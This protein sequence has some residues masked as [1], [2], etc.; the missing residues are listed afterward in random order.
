MR[1]LAPFYTTLDM[2]PSLT[3]F[4]AQFQHLVLGFLWRQWSA[5]GVAGQSRTGDPWVVDPE[6][7]LLFSTVLARHEP[8]LFDEILD[9]LHLNGS[10]INLQRLSH[11]QKHYEPGD[12]AVLAAIATHLAH[13]TA[14]SKWKVL[15]QVETTTNRPPTPLFS[16]LPFFGAEDPDFLRWGLLRAP[17]KL[18]GLSQSP[19][20]NQPATFLFK[21]RALFGRLA[22]A[23]I[24]AWLLTHDSGHPA[25]IARDVGAMPRSVQNILNDLSI[26]GHV[27]A[28]RAAREKHFAVRH[29]EWRFL[30]TW[31]GAAE[32]PQWIHWAS[33]FRVLRRFH[34]LLQRP[35]LETM[36]PFSQAIE[37]KR[38]ID[39]ASLV[40]AGL[41]AHLTHTPSTT[42]PEFLE[43]TLKDLETLLG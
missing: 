27:R 38:A 43:A 40:K 17:L 31:Q 19:E 12:S 28:V 14:H 18:R 21:M 11:L 16:Q 9:W 24:M 8:R 25:Q 20:P 5:L 10:W 39:V 23:D 34:E 15:T 41:P 22:R 42:G 36:S 13:D 2:E 33:L 1:C 37:I 26:S 30:L 35:D 29:D 32:F 6:A 4:K 3:S 7:L